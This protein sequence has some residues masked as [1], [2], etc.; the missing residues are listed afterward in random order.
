MTATARY[1][2]YQESRRRYCGRGREPFYRLA[3]RYLP[4]DPGAVVVD[5]GAGAGKFAELLD[6]SDRY[7]NLYL[8]DGNPATVA[9]LADRFTGAIHH[10]CPEPL[11]F[12]DGSVDFLHCSHLVE[13]L[14]GTALRVFLDECDRVLADGG[15]LV[16]STPLL[17]DAFYEDLSHVKPYGPGVFCSYLCGGG[18]QRSADVVSDGYRVEELV[19]RSRFRPP[20]FDGGAGHRLMPVDFVVQ[21]S[22]KLAALIGFGTYER[23]GYTMVLRKTTENPQQR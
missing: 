14:D 18:G 1:R 21:C 16:I 5:A 12:E 20:T 10:V 2:E 17:W 6:L 9:D 22:R 11:P 7:S 19:Y 8:L 23:T 13:H 4:D 3:G 15:V